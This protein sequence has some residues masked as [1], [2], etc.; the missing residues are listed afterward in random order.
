MNLCQLNTF[1]LTFWPDYCAHTQQT[2]QKVKTKVFNWQRFI[3]MN[4][5]TYFLQNPYFSKNEK[6][7]K[8]AW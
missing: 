2:G 1:F 5:L 8:Y 3:C 6:I 4:L 7:E